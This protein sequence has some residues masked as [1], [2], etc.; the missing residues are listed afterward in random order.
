MNMTD[1]Q[2]DCMETTCEFFR[3]EKSNMLAE[4]KH[5]TVFADNNFG[6]L[7]FSKTENVFK[8]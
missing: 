7:K 8:F 5:N 2:S 3:Q 6:F 4:F 1:S